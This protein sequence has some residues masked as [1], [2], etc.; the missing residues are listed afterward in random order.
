MRR[1]DDEALAYLLGVIDDP[2]VA[3]PRRDALA[4]KLLARLRT[5]TKKVNE[6]ERSRMEDARASLA[7][8]LAGIGPEQA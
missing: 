6:A 5:N 2:L 7:R 4:L 3:R 1:K 8:K